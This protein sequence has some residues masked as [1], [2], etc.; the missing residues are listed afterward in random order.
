V[1]F[2]KLKFS[3]KI[4]PGKRKPLQS[5][6]LKSSELRPAAPISSIKISMKQ[7]AEAYLYSRQGKA[8]TNF[9]T[10]MPPLQLPLKKNFKV[11]LL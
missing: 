2:L 6:V 4:V 11:F 3:E 1:I 7:F 8:I 5:K 9:K 10:T